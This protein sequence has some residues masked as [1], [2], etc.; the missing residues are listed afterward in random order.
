MRY[1]VT[2]GLTSREA[3]EQAATYFGHGGV[4]AMWRSP[5]NPAPRRRWK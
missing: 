2:T 1:E 3:L 4:G 5:C